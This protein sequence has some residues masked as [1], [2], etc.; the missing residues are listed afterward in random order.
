MPEDG[1]SRP[2][3]LNRRGAGSESLRM[4][5][6]SDLADLIEHGPDYA[7]TLR[8]ACGDLPMSDVE[9]F[10]VEAGQSISPDAADLCRRCEVRRECLEHAVARDFRSGYFGGTSP[11]AR[12][13]LRVSSGV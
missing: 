3:A 6:I 11:N 12:K 2:P 1:P 9:L 10:F 5:T 4:P 8:S 7:W 13:S